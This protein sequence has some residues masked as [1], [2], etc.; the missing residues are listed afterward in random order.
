[1]AIIKP[2]NLHPDAYFTHYINLAEGNDLLPSL[3][4]S[5]AQTIRVLESISSRQEG[6]RYAPKKWTVKQ[7]FQHINDTERIM[8]YRAL[9]FLRKDI[10]ELKGYNEDDFATEDSS[11]ELSLAAIQSEYVAIREA[12]IQLFENANIDNIDFVGTANQVK[13]TPRMIGWIIVGHSVH[14]QNVIHDRYLNND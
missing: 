14:H 9:R 10:T 5:K 3:E 13:L 8:A 12:T 4:S 7:V 1:M 6:Y 11:E 2:A